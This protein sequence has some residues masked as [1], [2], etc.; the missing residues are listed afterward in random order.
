MRG[1]RNK[2]ISPEVERLERSIL[3]QRVEF[4][5]S[6]AGE[7]FVDVVAKRQAA[8]DGVAEKLAVF[9]NTPVFPIPLWTALTAFISNISAIVGLLGTNLF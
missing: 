6:L 3:E 7:A 1:Y 5:K 4:A 8:I 2:Y 9:R